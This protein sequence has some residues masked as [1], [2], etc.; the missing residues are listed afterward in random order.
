MIKRLKY[1]EIDWGKYQKCLENSKQYVF[2]AEKK[3][4]NLLI[5]N[6]WDVLVYG[7]YEAVMPVPKVK[8]LGFYFV[9]MPLQTQQLGIFSRVD[10]P[11]LND[12]FYH[13]LRRNYHI[14]YYAFN[15]KNTFS[16]SLDKRKNFVLEKDNY[17]DIR[18]KY[19]I[20]RRRN[21][22][23]LESNRDKI[24]FEETKNIE[25]DYV[26]FKEHLVGFSDARIVENAFSN[27]KML[28]RENE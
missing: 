20:H 12:Q 4:L 18:K 24:R 28:F 8:K 13:F 15:A 26:F 27:M 17:E 2:F 5:N 1:N 21:V 10:D 22:R 25:K 19:S 23:I 16:L 3:Y 14:F 9:L 7:D 11:Q 6:H